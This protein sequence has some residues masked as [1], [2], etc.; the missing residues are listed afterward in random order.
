ME[1]VVNFESFSKAKYKEET[2][3]QRTNVVELRIFSVKST[4]LAVSR[5]F[6]TSDPVRN[7]FKFCHSLS[8]YRCNMLTLQA[9]VYT[10]DPEYELVGPFG[11][12]PQEPTP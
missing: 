2:K 1:K 8:R 12:M 7:T 10:E 11:T 5:P 4:L 6:Q 9:L 3:Y